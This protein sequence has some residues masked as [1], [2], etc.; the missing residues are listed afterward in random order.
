MT[1]VLIHTFTFIRQT[2]KRAWV[3]SLGCCIKVRNGDQRSSVDRHQWINIT[4]VAAAGAGGSRVIWTVN[5]I[6]RLSFDFLL[7]ADSI[8]HALQ[9]LFKHHPRIK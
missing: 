8:L 2:V 9:F 3:G 4:A 6:Y 5:V 7:A 1:P